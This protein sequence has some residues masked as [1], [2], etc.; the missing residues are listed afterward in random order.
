MKY[1]KQKQKKKCFQNVVT[2]YYNKKRP[3]RGRLTV[4]IYGWVVSIDKYA[5]IKVQCTHFK[6]NLYYL[7]TYFVRL[8]NRLNI[9][10]TYKTFCVYK[11]HMS[12]LKMC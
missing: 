1:V 6:D 3:Y 4:F 11:I 10:I 12:K 5:D 8:M 2:L 9:L 7:S